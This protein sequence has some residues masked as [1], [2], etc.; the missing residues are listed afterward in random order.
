ME[1][2]IKPSEE[3]K[4]YYENHDFAYSGDAGLD[5]FFVKEVTIPAKQ[6]VM[7][8]LEIALKFK[9]F[10]SKFKINNK[11]L[12][13]VKSCLLLS[14]S[15]IYKTPLRLAN[16]IGLIDSGYRGNIKV[17]VDNISDFDYTVKPGQKLFQIV[18]HNL[19]NFKLVLTHDLGDTARGSNGFGSSSK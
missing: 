16:G 18:A 9:Q 17:A 8:D 13:S 15:S 19:E 10:N 6:T 5:L 2:H 14:R 4:K 11:E 12:Y 3:A 7:I 1:L